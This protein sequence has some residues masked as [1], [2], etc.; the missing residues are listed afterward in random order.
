SFWLQTEALEVAD[1]GQFALAE[2]RHQITVGLGAN[3]GN[4]VLNPFDAVRWEMFNLLQR[5]EYFDDVFKSAVHVSNG[6]IDVGPYRHLF[7]GF[8]IGVKAAA[9]G[10]R[11]VDRA[12]SFT[13]SHGC[14]LWVGDFG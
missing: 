9:L 5:L 14:L 11:Q 3:P 10:L 8:L 2:H 6:P 1:I 7:G 12:F 4:L 13:Y